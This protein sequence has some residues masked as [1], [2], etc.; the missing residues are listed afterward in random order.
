MEI[1][2]VIDE[3][4]NIIGTASKEECHSNPELIH[5]TVQF[6]LVDIANKNV[7]VTQRSFNKAHDPGKITFLGEHVLSGESLDEGLI[8]GV[9]EELGFTPENFTP[10]ITHIFQYDKQT[11]RVTFYVGFW[12]GEKIDWDKSE[13]E[14]VEWRDLDKLLSLD[15]DYSEMAKF[16]IANVD[17]EGIFKE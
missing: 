2:D 13:L 10:A 1:L 7:F 6:T 14:M 15:D 3:E 12:N 8:R 5:R 11:E 9:E 4:G 16:W 17:W